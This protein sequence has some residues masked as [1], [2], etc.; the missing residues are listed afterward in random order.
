M[1]GTVLRREEKERW[2]RKILHQ[3]PLFLPPRG[4]VFVGGG[5]QISLCRLTERGEDAGEEGG[6]PEC[7]V[8]SKG[9]KEGRGAE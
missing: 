5:R 9:R 7:E 1:K 6:L 4:G 3:F 8:K 2:R